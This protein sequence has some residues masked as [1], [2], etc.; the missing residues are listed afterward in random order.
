MS[1]KKAGI[2][3]EKSERLTPVQR[4][5]QAAVKR[6]NLAELV[7]LAR[8]EAAEM[9]LITELD[10]PHAPAEQ[11]AGPAKRM[12]DT[13]GAYWV[14]WDSHSALLFG[15]YVMGLCIGQFLYPDVFRS[16]AGDQ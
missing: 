1:K 8:P 16:K 3:T 2:T 6:G 14:D 12:R 11:L 9:I 7:R 13:S 15:A 10:D 4:A 5:F